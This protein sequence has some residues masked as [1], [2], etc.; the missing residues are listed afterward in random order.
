MGSNNQL[1]NVCHVGRK[2]IGKTEE[3]MEKMRRNSSEIVNEVRER[4]IFKP[5][6]PEGN[7]GDH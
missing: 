4:G 3:E 6:R 1:T 2:R 5:R 7:A